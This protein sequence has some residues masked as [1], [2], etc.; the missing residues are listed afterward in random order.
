MALSDPS[1]SPPTIVDAIRERTTGEKHAYLDGYKAGIRRMMELDGLDHAY[2]WLQTADHIRDS[3]A[4]E[5]T[6]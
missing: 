6:E 1:N 4:H 3:L 5:S 2:L